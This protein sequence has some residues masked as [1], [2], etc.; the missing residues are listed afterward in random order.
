MGK[1]LFRMG[2]R[3]FLLIGFIS[4]IVYVNAIHND[5]QYD[6]EVCIT[7]NPHI[8]EI[9]NIPYFFTHPE[10]LTSYEVK[11]H[12]RPLVPVSYALN[13]AVGGLNPAGYR[14]VNLLFHIGTAFLLY[15]IIK[16]MLG[17]GEEHRSKKLEV[18]SET[19]SNI[20]PL[21]SNFS[22]SSF[23]ALPLTPNF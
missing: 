23:S 9:E 16:A 2:Y 11:A 22:L 5:F 20:L 13:F 1:D 12:Y 17:G 8:R 7:E 4:A 10:Y 3:A 19:R 15:L 14:I 18:R 6:D 21:T